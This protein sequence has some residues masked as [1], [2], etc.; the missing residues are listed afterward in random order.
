MTAVLQ[1]ERTISRTGALVVSGYAVV[2]PFGVGR[3]A[4]ADG[5]ASGATGITRVDQEAH[6]GPYPEAGTIPGFSP[7]AHLGGKGTR[8]MDRLTAIAI[9]TVG[10]LVQECGPEVTADAERVGLVLGTGSGSVQSI[11]DFTRESLAGEKPYH[12]DPARFP[13]TVMNKAAGQSA[14]WHGIKGPNTTVTGD[15][16]T[17]LLA[18]SYS[19]RLYRGGHCDRVLCGAVEEYSTQ[20]AWLEYRAWDGHGQAPPLGEGGVVFLLESET[21]ARAAGRAALATIAAT[22]FR[23]FATPA[24]AIDALVRCIQDALAQAGK[25]PSDVTLVAPS[26]AG[27]VAGEWEESALTRVLGTEVERVVSRRAIGDTSAASTSFQV[28]SVLARGGALDGG[29]GLVTAID[30]DGTVGCV[31]LGEPS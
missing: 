18:L 3:A 30:R 20:R 12:V 13:N 5:L 27:N 7:A 19:T 21:A 8:S 25:S 6:P 2:S 23:A 11:M 17:G 9:A 15:W 16:L 24:G 1:E 14:I 4:F 26:A 10:A 28:A 31:L 29:L 22:R